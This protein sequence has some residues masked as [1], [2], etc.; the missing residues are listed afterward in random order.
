MPAMT[1]VIKVSDEVYEKLRRL[2]EELGRKKGRRVTMSEVIE[3]V[4]K[5]IRPER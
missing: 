4:L 2:T 5:Q 1:K 3:E